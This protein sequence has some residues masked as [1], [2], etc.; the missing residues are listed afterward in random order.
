MIVD[1]PRVTGAEPWPT[2]AISPRAAGAAARPPAQPDQPLRDH[3]TGRQGRQTL[4]T[5]PGEDG[6][7]SVGEI[8]DLEIVVR[9][10]TW[11]AR[12]GRG[13]CA[14]GPYRGHVESHVLDLISAPSTIVAGSPSLGA[15]T[16]GLGGPARRTARRPSSPIPPGTRSKQAFVERRAVIL[17]RPR[18][19][20]EGR[21]GV[22]G[23]EGFSEPRPRGPDRPSDDDQSGQGK[24]ARSSR[25]PTTAGD[26]QGARDHS[27]RTTSSAAAPVR[28]RDRGLKLGVDMGASTSSSRSSRRRS[29]ASA[30]AARRAGRPP[31]R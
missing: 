23:R 7:A 17:R 1:V 15:A 18:R 4:A 11:P 25:G 6:R 14:P 8:K 12:R 5:D 22:D 26:L 9:S 20:L 16:A 10:R 3:A 30:S 13:R 27:S 29:V 24:R 21:R 2:S 28:R 19:R 31:G